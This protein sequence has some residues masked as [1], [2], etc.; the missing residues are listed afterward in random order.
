MGTAYTMYT[1]IIL[2]IQNDQMCWYNWV[3]VFFGCYHNKKFTHNN[4]KAQPQLLT[5]GSKHKVGYV[6]MSHLFGFIYQ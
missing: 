5:P 3:E 4:Y 6:T 1:N 2:H